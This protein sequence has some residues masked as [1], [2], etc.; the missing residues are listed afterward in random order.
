MLTP[1]RT[2]QLLGLL[3][4]S[5][6]ASSALAASPAGQLVAA[7]WSAQASPE[8]PAA[9]HDNPATRPFVCVSDQA[10]HHPVPAIST[11]SIDVDTLT[12]PWPLASQRYGTVRYSDSRAYSRT[13]GPAV[14]SG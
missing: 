2:W 10:N 13:T 11:L 7:S 14:P 5:L 8:P 6:T 4:V 12:G 9:P 1:H 3:A